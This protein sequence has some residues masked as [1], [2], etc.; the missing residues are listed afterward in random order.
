LAVLS[1]VAVAFLLLA[2]LCATVALQA[3]D[4]ANAVPKY[5]SN[6]L[7]RWESLRQGPPGPLNV[8]VR[9]LHDLV[10]DLGKASASA[11]DVSKAQRPTPVEVVSGGENL[12]AWAQSGL[13]PLVGPA[14][15]FAVVVLLVVFLLL[16]R[17]RLRQRFLRLVGHS[18]TATTTL[19]VDGERLANPI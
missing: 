3:L 12:L 19:A 16:E 15:E 10:D 5:P 8:A 9:N 13:T 18:H 4:L 17:G 2:A 14:T 7:A 11:V 6:V 1:V